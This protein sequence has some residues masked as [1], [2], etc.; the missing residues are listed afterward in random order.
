MSSSRQFMTELHSSRIVG[1]YG[2]AVNR[3][4]QD[5][6]DGFP[7][8]RAKGPRR[9]YRHPYGR[10]A[11]KGDSLSAQWTDEYKF[12]P[13]GAVASDPVY[14]PLIAMECQRRGVRQGAP[15]LRAVD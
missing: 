1:P 6:P 14:G 5:R 10:D 7:G 2:S 11:G 13:F 9:H 3:G 4:N 12:L 8:L 15:T